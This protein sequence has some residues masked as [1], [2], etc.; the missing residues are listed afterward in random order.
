MHISRQFS[1]V[2]ALTLVCLSL[3]NAALANHPFHVSTA[4]VEFNAKTKRLEVGLKCQTTDLERALRLMAGKKIDIES[5]PQV[6]ELVKRYVTENFYL[7]V[8]PANTKAET[9]KNTAEKAATSDATPE[10]PEPPK[11]PI[12]LVGK[13]FETKWI[14]IYF[15]LQPPAGDQPLVLVNRVLFEVNTGQINT[16]LIRHNGKRH[17]LKS[18]A[19]KPL[20]EY[21]RSWLTSSTQSQ[22]Q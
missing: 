20:Q 19:N 5:D 2:C 13:E 1:F 15:E 12:K 18:T 10:V 4:E 3:T 14:W 8:A 16:C 17:A 21:D 9:P 11:E 6:D 7:S 22:P